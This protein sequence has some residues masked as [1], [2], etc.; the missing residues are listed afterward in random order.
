M[1]NTP[2]RPTAPNNAMSEMTSIIKELQVRI[3]RLEGKREEEMIYF[4]A[5]SG[6]LKAY[7]E[8]Y[9][10]I[11]NRKDLMRTGIIDSQKFARDAVQIFREGLSQEE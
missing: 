9:A 5:Y 2:P 10:N 8:K 4:S 3:E 11:A 7:V 6:Y 1:T